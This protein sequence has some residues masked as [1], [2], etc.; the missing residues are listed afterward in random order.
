LKISISRS[1]R[2]KRNVSHVGEGLIKGIKGER[3]RIN[4]DENKVVGGE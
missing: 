3:R 1:R 2:E 4:C